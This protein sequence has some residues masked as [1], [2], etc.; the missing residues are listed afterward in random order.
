MIIAIQ[1]ALLIAVILFIADLI[2][3]LYLKSKQKPETNMLGNLITM[4]IMAILANELTTDKDKDK[5][6]KEKVK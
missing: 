4:S 6:T 1:I 3:D 5:K 2:I